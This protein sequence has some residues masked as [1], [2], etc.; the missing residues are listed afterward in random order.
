M[1]RHSDV[2]NWLNETLDLNIEL[3]TPGILSTTT[4]CPIGTTLR[5]TGLFMQV[6]VYPDRIT[7]S[8]LDLTTKTFY[9]PEFMKEWILKC[10]DGDFPE[11]AIHLDWYKAEEMDED[12][13]K[14][15]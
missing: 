13:P 1:K 5:W 11:I 8:W 3:I 7:V 4:F 10:D 15:C 6:G 2:I 9:L 14:N 12:N